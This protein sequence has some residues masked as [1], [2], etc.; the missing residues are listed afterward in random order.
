[1]GQQGKLPCSKKDTKQELADL[2][3]REEKGWLEKRWKRFQVV[4]QEGQRLEW[5]SAPFLPPKGLG[6]GGVCSV[7][8]PGRTRLIPGWSHG[9]PDETGLPPQATLQQRL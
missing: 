3:Q 6:L 1:M 7:R 5:T 9:P 2:K 8:E 4:A